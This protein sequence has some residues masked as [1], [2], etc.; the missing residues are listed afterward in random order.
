[1]CRLLEEYM[2]FG[3][4][5]RT[6]SSTGNMVNRSEWDE[7]F[8]NF[9]A[10]YQLYSAGIKEIRTKLEI[11]D[12]EFLLRYD[13]DPIHHIESR[14]KAPKGITGKLE[15]KGIPLSTENVVKYV[16]DV[17]GIRVICSY[18]EDIYQI[19]GMLLRQSDITLV[20][21]KD[22]IKQPKQS[23]YRS[24][25]LVV[26][27]PIYLSDQV[28]EVLVEVQLRTIA[29]DFWATLEHQIKY[30]SGMTVPEHLKKELCDCSDSIAE[31]DRR[32]QRIHENIRDSALQQIASK[33]SIFTNP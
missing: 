13:H 32:M 21:K 16:H 33:E 6:F 23:G 26:S 27:I 30:K 3:D 20:R 5:L 1:M 22:Y 10:L 7:R 2:D 8:E 28:E 19:S 12:S 15:K 31:L 9:T 14:L 18:I 11:L 17:A 4:V 24:L 29:M 25:H